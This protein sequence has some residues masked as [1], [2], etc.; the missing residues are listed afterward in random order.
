MNWSIRLRFPGRN[1]MVSF[2]L[3]VVGWINRFPSVWGRFQ[4]ELRWCRVLIVFFEFTSCSVHKNV[5][6]QCRWMSVQV[7]SR[8]SAQRMID[9]SA[10]ECRFRLV[11]ISSA[12]NDRSLFI[13]FRNSAGRWLVSRSKEKWINKMP[14]VNPKEHELVDQITIPW[15]K[16]D[17]FFC[18]TC[19]R[20]N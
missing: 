16:R 4:W 10:N 8:F 17:G 5:R 1:V 6:S 15:T 13:I 12:K 11:K 7:R 19:S 3:H 2:A 18:A 9:V 20:L 14:K